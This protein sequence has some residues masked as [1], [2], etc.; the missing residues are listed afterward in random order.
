MKPIDMIPKDI[1]K[2]ISAI[3]DEKG[4]SQES[5]AE[6][7]KTP[8]PNLSKKENCH[9]P[10]T[11]GE[12][13]KYCREIGLDPRDAF[14]EDYKKPEVK[15]DA[16]DAEIMRLVKTLP[17]SSKRDILKNVKKEIKLHRMNNENTDPDML[18][19]SADSA[20]NLYHKNKKKAK[21]SA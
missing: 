5:V 7:I 3:R 14:S 12:F 18:H 9:I 13:I 11:L 16:I 4:I 10:I 19:K 6:A 8:R 15:Y 21:S 2:K 17:P 20:K 1:L